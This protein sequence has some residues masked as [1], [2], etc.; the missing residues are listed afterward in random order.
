[1]TSRVPLMLQPADL[2]VF[3]PPLD[4]T[5]PGLVRVQ[6]V[7]SLSSVR[8]TQ[9]V[10]V[11]WGGVLL[12][13]PYPTTQL[14]RVASTGKRRLPSEIDSRLAPRLLRGES[15][16]VGEWV[17]LWLPDFGLLLD[18]V[19]AQITQVQRQRAR[20]DL[21][22]ELRFAPDGRSPGQK[23][24]IVPIQPGKLAWSAHEER[25]E[26][27]LNQG[28]PAAERAHDL[29]SRRS[30]ERTALLVTQADSVAFALR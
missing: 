25:T 28:R 14:R 27:N 4:R 5:Y 18:G 16:Q 24:T 13:E 1:M 26:L 2:V 17:W 22:P 6:G 29:L 3:R 21:V 9:T 15:W 12:P 11:T 10:R 30:P 19:L 23:S 7:H 20:V 8:Q